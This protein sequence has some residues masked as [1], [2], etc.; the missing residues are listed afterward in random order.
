MYLKNFYDSIVPAEVALKEQTSKHFVV[1]ARW[2][3]LSNSETADLLGVSHIAICRVYLEWC[4]KRKHPVSV[5]F[6]GK[7]VC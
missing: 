3:G 5:N 1:G 4:M 7:I 6:C 2:T